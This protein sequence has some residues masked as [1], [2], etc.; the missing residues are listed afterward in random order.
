M[1]VASASSSQGPEDSHDQTDST[2]PAAEQPEDLQGSWTD[3]ECMQAWR[4]PS[5]S[6]GVQLRRHTLNLLGVP[7]EFMYH[8]FKKSLRMSR[9]GAAAEEKIDE[10]TF[11]AF[12]E[13]MLRATKDQQLWDVIDNASYGFVNKYSLVP[14]FWFHS[15]DA[16]DLVREEPG[17]W[18]PVSGVMISTPGFNGSRGTAS[19]SDKRPPF[20]DSAELVVD[21]VND[22]LQQGREED[23]RQGIPRNV[24]WT[25]Q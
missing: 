21:L 15:L 10:P 14:R 1:L 2:R 11:P 7:A 25:S 17:D 5:N 23:P 16:Q 9:T 8:E 6:K 3:E 4:D 22:N 13:A 18:G 12:A 19:G 24:H 20:I